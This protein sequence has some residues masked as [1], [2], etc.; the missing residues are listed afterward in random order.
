M[1][2]LGSA[3]PTDYLDAPPQST[4]SCLPATSYQ[5]TRSK[6]RHVVVGL[7]GPI[8]LDWCLGRGGK[9]KR[10]KRLALA[11]APVRTHTG[12]SPPPLSQGRGANP[13]PPHPAH[14][15]HGARDRK[16]E[17]GHHQQPQLTTAIK[18][19]ATQPRAQ[20]RQSRQRRRPTNQEKSS[21]G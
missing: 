19:A 7:A 4:K 21:G 10:G 12:P 1:P 9:R 16:D 17:H 20:P 2:T 14:N 6:T 3:H 5:Y 18:A 11:P 8:E 13:N 15:P